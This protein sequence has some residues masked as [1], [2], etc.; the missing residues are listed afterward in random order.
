MGLSSSE[1]RVA[2]RANALGLDARPPAR[3]FASE[4]SGATHDGMEKAT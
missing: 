4:L 2:R 3:A 1:S